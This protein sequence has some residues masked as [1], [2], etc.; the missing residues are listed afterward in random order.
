MNLDRL[1][2]PSWPTVD[3][4]PIVRGHWRTFGGFRSSLKF[5]IKHSAR[6]LDCLARPIP[7]G[8]GGPFE[9]F[10]IRLRYR[11]LAFFGFVFLA[12]ACMQPP[13]PQ[14]AYTLP[15]LEP[16]RP[17]SSGL[18][19]H[20]PGIALLLGRRKYSQTARQ[21]PFN[22]GD[23]WQG[24]RLY[25]ST[26]IEP[27]GSAVCAIEQTYPDG[28]RIAVG[29]SPRHLDLVF[30]L[31]TQATPREMPAEFSV[32]FDDETEPQS[33]QATIF[34]HSSYLI[35]FDGKENDLLN[36]LSHARSLKVSNQGKQDG[37][38]SLA[39]SERAIQALRLCLA[40]GHRHRPT[41]HS[42]S[43][44]AGLPTSPAGAKAPTE[45]DLDAEPAPAPAGVDLDAAPA[46]SSAA[47]PPINGGGAGK[48]ASGAVDL[49]DP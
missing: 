26:E 41:T 7:S 36:R 4:L 46:A 33:L 9:Q 5:G 3:N 20:D 6:A 49:D 25:G 21:T 38:Y 18:V 2:S 13:P 23:P 35:S 17:I 47:S 1:P 48:G 16:L 34:Y 45:V 30:G 10:Q 43:S 15:P 12:S 44:L 14:P 40:E 8:R 37:D 19:T 31:G 39:G 27:G 11:F 29:G 24:T 32:A 28:R 22:A 42:N